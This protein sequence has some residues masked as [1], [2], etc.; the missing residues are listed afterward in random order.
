M[1]CLNATAWRLFTELDAKRQ[2]EAELAVTK[3]RVRFASDLHDIQGHT[4]HVV[5][6]KTALAQKLVDRDPSRAHDELRQVQDLISE[7]ISQTNSLAY[8]SRSLTLSAEIENAKN[9]FEAAGIS[10]N[11]NQEGNIRPELEEPVSLVLRE[12]TTNIL[13]HAQAQSVGIVLNQSSI[14]I[15]NDGCAPGPE[16]QLRGLA[17]LRKR[18]H[19][20]GGEMEIAKSRSSFVT[21]AMFPS[22]EEGENDNEHRP[23][24]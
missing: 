12:A 16:P 2:T 13:R 9:L 20:R 10:V 11:V 7:T 23:C 3:E 5:K 4:L 22:A 6:L 14:A 19:E 17:A 18:V 15:T 21:A 24:R 8:G 1:F